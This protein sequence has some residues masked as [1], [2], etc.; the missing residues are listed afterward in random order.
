MPTESQEQALREA[1]VVTADMAAQVANVSLIDK[2]TGVLVAVFYSPKR[3]DALQ[4]AV[5]YAQAETSE[6]LPAL[7][8]R[9]EQQRDEI[10]RLKAVIADEKKDG[11]PRTSKGAGGK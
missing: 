10:A 3:D 6:E 8:R 4:M 7:T 11:K 2:K 1:Y 5:T 9:F